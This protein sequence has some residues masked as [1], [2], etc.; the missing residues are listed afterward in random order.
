MIVRPYFL[1]LLLTGS[2][3]AQRSPIALRVERLFPESSYRTVFG[4]CTDLWY[5]LRTVQEKSARPWEQFS[6][7]MVDSLVTLDTQVKV[8]A[9]E[10]RHAP[11]DLEHLLGIL[12]LMHG[13]YVYASLEKSPD[14]QVFH[15]V[16]Y[17]FRR[18]KQRLE[19]LLNGAAK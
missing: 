12:Q 11:D 16:S 7:D 17:F 8:L 9:S 10:E 3:S 5:Q 18:I 15:A 14:Q 6:D 13:E 19:Q 2:L 4:K 1:L